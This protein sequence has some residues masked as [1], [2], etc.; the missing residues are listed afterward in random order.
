MRL[1]SPRETAAA[2]RVGLVAI[3]RVGLVAVAHVDRCA[4]PYLRGTGRS[5]SPTWDRS[6][7][8]AWDRRAP[9]ASVG[10]RSPAWA[11]GRGCPR[12][13]GCRRPRGT[14]LPSPTW[15]RRASR[16]S[17]GL[18]ISHVGPI[19]I[20]HVGPASVARGTDLPPIPD[21]LHHTADQRCS[22]TTCIAGLLYTPLDLTIAS[23]M[24][25]WV[26]II[27]SM[28]IVNLT[29]TGMDSGIQIDVRLSD[30]FEIEANGASLTC[31]TGPLHG[32]SLRHTPRLPP[33][34]AAAGLSPVSA[35]TRSVRD[36]RSPDRSCSPP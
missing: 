1:A 16:A 4:S 24:L 2:S 13:T 29:A 25:E 15:D 18:A 21:L 26:Y 5:P 20:A 28:L 11:T 8:P 30:A 31:S 9:R 23:R 27:R 22:R 35:P 33:P 17:V 36:E 10:L 19:A 14:R 6:P 34:L 3:S 32:T 12:G 7:S